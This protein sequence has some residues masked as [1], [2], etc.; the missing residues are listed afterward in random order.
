MQQS[1]QN[2]IGHSYRAMVKKKNKLMKTWA[3]VWANSPKPVWSGTTQT[4]LGWLVYW[5]KKFRG[6][7]T[8]PHSCY[9]I[10]RK[11]SPRPNS[12]K[13]KII[14][15]GNSLAV[16][17][18]GFCAFTAKGRGSIA[19]QGTSIPR[20][21]KWKSLSHVQPFATPWT[22]SW[23]SPGQNTRVGSLS[24]LQGISPTRD[25]TQVSRIAGSFLTRWA[26]MEAQE[27]WSG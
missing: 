15:Y 23:N 22:S 21:S 11:A 7:F 9:H 20:A 17:W 25:Q 1:I 18:V 14:Y 5:S 13:H 12:P 4:L 19:G 2:L 3:R 16:Q 26:K 8:P 6:V 24:L 27:Y 10:I